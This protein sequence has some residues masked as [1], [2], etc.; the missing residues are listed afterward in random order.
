MMQKKEIIFTEFYPPQT[1]SGH[2]KG[3]GA[4]ILCGKA[5]KL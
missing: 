3:H 1:R 5:D 4:G 2:D